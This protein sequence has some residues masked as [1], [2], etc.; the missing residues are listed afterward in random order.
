MFV[1]LQRKFCFSQ[2]QDKADS[3]AAQA[4]ELLE[5]HPDFLRCKHTHGMNTMGITTNL[6][7]DLGIV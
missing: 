7:I 3:N 6:M 1:V 4:K 2:R 5:L